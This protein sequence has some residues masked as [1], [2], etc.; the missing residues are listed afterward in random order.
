M[1][2]NQW[3]QFSVSTP[4]QRAL[5]EVI[6]RAQEP[7]ESFSSYYAYVN[8]LYQRK[9][10]YLVESLQTVRLT[11]YIPE[12]GFFVMADTSAYSFPSKYEEQPG[13]DGSSPVTRDWGFAR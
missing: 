5:A 9:R 12:G 1:L 7:Y 10:D 8:Q 13:P 2:A 3:V 11:P 4:T 6:R